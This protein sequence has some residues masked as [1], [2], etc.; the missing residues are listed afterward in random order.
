[1]LIKKIEE[2]LDNQIKVEIKNN[3][4]S[5][6]KDNKFIVNNY[7]SLGTD[8]GTY[9]SPLESA[10]RDY[11][12]S[13]DTQSLL[14]NTETTESV[15]WREHKLVEKLEILQALH[16]RTGETFS[17]RFWGMYSGFST[18]RSSYDT[19]E[20]GS[21]ELDEKRLL[22]ALVEKRFPVKMI[23]TLNVA[24]VLSFGY[25]VDNIRHRIADMC[26]VCEKLSRYDNFSFVIDEESNIDSIIA[27]DELFMMKQYDFENAS[28]NYR[29]ADWTSDRHKIRDFCIKFDQRYIGLEQLYVNMCRTLQLDGYSSYV[30]FAIENRINNYLK[31]RDIL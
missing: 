20:L 31:E 19:T 4:G 23:L 5:E 11:M 25:S 29:K 27:V 24:K 7:V 13:S 9:L 21:L 10:K 1:M 8:L 12:K 15:Y 28:F 18:I 14:T 30:I 26:E 16:N 22:M 2:I 6:V 17:I 3:K